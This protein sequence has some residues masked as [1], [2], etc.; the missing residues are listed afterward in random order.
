MI[1]LGDSCKFR[2]D[3]Y[4]LQ[5]HAW[6]ASGYE[7]RYEVLVKELREGKWMRIYH[8]FNGPLIDSYNKADAFIAKILDTKESEDK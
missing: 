4:K 2:I 7:K 8:S 5:C 1:A 3:M 6:Y